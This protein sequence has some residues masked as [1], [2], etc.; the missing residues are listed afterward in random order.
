[1]ASGTVGGGL[2]TE[3]DFIIII[4]VIMIIIF[5][6]NDVVFTVCVYLGLLPLLIIIVL[7]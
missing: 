3:V 6:I 7:L 4:I 2:K 1:M 5:I